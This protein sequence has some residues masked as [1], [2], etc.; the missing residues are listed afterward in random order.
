MCSSRLLVVADRRE[1]E[2]ER[3]PRDQ[4]PNCLCSFCCL[5][6]LCCFLLKKSKCKIFKFQ[7]KTIIFFPQ[8]HVRC[9]AGSKRGRGPQETKFLI[10]PK[11]RIRPN[12]STDGT[13]DA[14]FIHRPSYKRDKIT[15]ANIIPHFSGRSSVFYG[16]EC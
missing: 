3:P 12:Y 11:L 6:C 15:Q 10:E 9:A 5:C 7:R 14:S 13:I 4:I 16:L 8:I 1:A 2:A